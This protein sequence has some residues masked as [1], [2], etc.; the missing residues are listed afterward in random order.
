MVARCVATAAV[1]NGSLQDRGGVC[2]VGNPA[3]GSGRLAE[4]FLPRSEAALALV[5][6]GRIVERAR[7]CASTGV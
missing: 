7:E 5:G 3:H 6:P 4:F 1:V 2:A